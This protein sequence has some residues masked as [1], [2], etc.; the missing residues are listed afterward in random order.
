[1]YCL[2]KFMDFLKK[3]KI[4]ITLFLVL[5]L[6]AALRI[7]KIGDESFWMDEYVTWY[8]LE[9]SSF[10]EMIAKSLFV[11][12]YPF[13]FI[14]IRAYSWLAGSSDISLRLFS[15]IFGVLTVYFSFLVGKKMFS[16]KVGLLSAFF[17]ALSPIMIEYSQEARMYTLI[18]F[19]AL[20]SLLA[21]LRVR[22]SGYRQGLLWLGLALFFGAYTHAYFLFFLFA[23]GIWML[24]ESYRL[25][26]LRRVV[27]LL[28]ALA[29][30]S[31]PLL[32]STLSGMIWPRQFFPISTWGHKDLGL[33]VRMGLESLLLR[34]SVAVYVPAAH[35][36]TLPLNAA[37]V[38]FGFFA[39]IFVFKF[40]KDQRWKIGLLLV[41]S[42]LPFAIPLLVSLLWAEI[43]SIHYLL[44]IIPFLWIVISFGIV[45]FPYAKIGLHRR[46]FIIVLL[47]AVGAVSFFTLSDY[48]RE[49][50]KAPW[51]QTADFLTARIGPS[52]SVVMIDELQEVYPV[53]SSYYLKDRLPVYVDGQIDYSSL[54][55]DIW[56]IFIDGME[57]NRQS[58]SNFNLLEEKELYGFRLL[59]VSYKK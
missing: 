12:H 50:H 36:Y 30:S 13:Y 58:V 59:R 5:A 46:T 23:L 25:G 39:S 52:D 2:E 1:V 42:L 22:E 57:L 19:L 56:L 4:A 10:H 16:S 32:W 51:K 14:L 43:F 53:F 37:M 29:L 54:P 17:V 6:A 28:S 9:R 31:S 38:F 8:S 35:R 21:F 40:W 41:L 47:A 34:D 55:G 49:Y 24:F 26:A 48:Y 44:Y 11:G 15:A 27:F 18:S 7:F 33:I 3:N 20:A 45:H